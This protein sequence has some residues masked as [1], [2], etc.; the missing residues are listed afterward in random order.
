MEEYGNP[1]VAAV[2]KDALP[3]LL[4]LPDTAPAQQ[5]DGIVA[6]VMEQVM[7][8]QEVLTPAFVKV[9]SQLV[10]V[11]SVLIRSVRPPPNELK[12]ALAT[13]L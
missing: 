8:G 6:N 5:E 3:T 9:Q 11:D 4:E 2:M 7:A 10:L 1:V 13:P 12:T